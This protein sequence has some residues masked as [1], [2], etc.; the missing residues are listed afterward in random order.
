VDEDGTV[1]LEASLLTQP[2]TDVQA[3]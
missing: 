3:F 2:L 1:C